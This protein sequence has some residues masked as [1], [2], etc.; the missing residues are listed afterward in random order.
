M[1]ETTLYNFAHYHASPKAI[2]LA[3][4]VQKDWG[5]EE[6]IVNNEKY[7]GKKLVFKPR[8]QCSLHYHKIKEE[9][10]YIVAGSV[11]LETE[12]HGIKQNRIMEPGDI[13]HIPISMLH[14]LSALTFAEVMEFSTFHMDE[15]SYRCIP[16]GKADFKAMG[17]DV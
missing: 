8:Y 1:Q 5:H 2:Q 9:T 15:D 4:L 13:A 11:Y 6:W 16:S 3:R 17:L 7:C 12:H 10:F 14:R